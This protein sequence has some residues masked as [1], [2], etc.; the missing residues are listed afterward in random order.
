MGSLCHE[1]AARADDELCRTYFDR[2]TI[3]KLLIES[4][5]ADIDGAVNVEEIEKMKFNLLYKQFENKELVDLTANKC[6]TVENMMRF[7]ADASEYLKG[8]FTCG[9]DAL[10]F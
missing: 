1:E 4:A 8:Q 9:I 6:V 3:W 2:D 10:T 5:G 7:I